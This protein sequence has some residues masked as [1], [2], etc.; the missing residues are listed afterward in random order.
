MECHSHLEPLSRIAGERSWLPL[1]Q[2]WSSG[3]QR[4]IEDESYQEDS[5]L[6]R[7][8]PLDGFSL[9]AFVE[10]YDNNRYRGKTCT[11]LCISEANLFLL[12]YLSFL[13]FNIVC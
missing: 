5:I 8:T 4:T 11:Y 10:N 6:G 7:A 12:S 13:K 1:G 2:V 9:E 3:S